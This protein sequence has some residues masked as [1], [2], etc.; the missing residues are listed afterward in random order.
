VSRT[1]AEL[2][3]MAAFGSIASDW[4]ARRRRLGPN[5]GRSVPRDA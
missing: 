1:S 5:F 3:F 2:G 4:F